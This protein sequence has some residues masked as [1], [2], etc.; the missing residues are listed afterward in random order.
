M[1]MFNIVRPAKF[2]EVVGQRLTIM[3]IQKGIKKCSFEQ[4]SIFFGK[5]GSGKT[6]AARIVAKALNC[7]DPDENGEPCCECDSCKAIQQG[8][9][10]DY[11]ELNAATNGGKDDIEALIANVS[12]LPTSGK[13]KV[14]VLDEVQCFSSAAWKSLLKVIEEPPV[15]TYFIMC[16]TEI[17][18]VPAEIQNRC[19]KYQFSNI[20]ETDVYEY[21]L[22]LKDRFSINYVDEA[23]KL[24]ASSAKGS[25]RDAVN[26]FEH[27]S[28]PFEPGHLIT[29]DDAQSYLSIVSEE[30]ILRLMSLIM[31]G[32]LSESIQ[33]V[34]S[35]ERAA[36]DA[37]SVIKQMI[38]ITS[39]MLVISAGV[40]TEAISIN[41]Q[42]FIRDMLS[43]AGLERTI[44]VGNILTEIYSKY[45]Q[46]ITYSVL[47]LAVAKA[48]IANIAD[49]QITESTV[50]VNQ[51][52]KTETVSVE[53]V[54]EK[55]EE[56]IFSIFGKQER[57]AGQQPE[58]C[59]NSSVEEVE[60]KDAVP[61][62]TT[63]GG[64][65]CFSSKELA[66]SFASE[67]NSL[68][69][70]RQLQQENPLLNKIVKM[71]DVSDDKDTISLATPFKPVADIVGAYI[72][73]L[74][75]KDV[76]VYAVDGLMCK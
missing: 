45:R 21:L 55:E 63:G 26:T 70:L 59:D 3:S 36:V 75:L 47:R 19:G 28:I 35:L 38:D 23:L 34:S 49:K 7:N 14:F 2:S 32:R 41:G 74:N 5:T 8:N 6:T 10:S 25:M 15:H 69:E 48:V 54:A 29:V 43:Q 61:F 9:F 37:F 18:A 31:Y 73:Y 17:S 1:A 64:N 24:I 4:S 40:E 65:I 57:E 33:I 56:D 46:N 66:E 11:Y 13:V 60:E 76:E 68:T 71:C 16:T 51:G 53:E 44:Y 67:K 12:Y 27:I 30:N 52:I 22:K 20:N 58:A 42:M 62:T 72:N 50:S 39:N